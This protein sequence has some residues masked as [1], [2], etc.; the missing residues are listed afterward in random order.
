MLYLSDTTLAS[1]E[2]GPREIVARI[3]HLLQGVVAGTVS[4][5]PK[6]TLYPGDG[7]LFMS[8][9]A[10]SE[11]PPYMTVKSLGMNP[12]NGERD[13]PSIG[14]HIAL[15]DAGTGL[16]VAMMDGTWITAVRTAALTAV[17]A[18]RLADADAATIAF[19]GCGVQARSHLDV[20]AELYPITHI[21]M[22]GRGKANID[23]LADRAGQLNIEA[24]RA[25]DSSAA[26]A[27]ADIVVSTVPPSV[28]LEAFLDANVLKENAFVSMVD[29][30]RSWKPQTL[31]AF[32]AI[33]VDDL[34][35]ERQMAS[36]M[37]DLSLV[38]RDLKSLVQQSPGSDGR[39]AFVF[40]GVAVGDLALAG[41][42]YERALAGG[43][44]Q[45]LET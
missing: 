41:L 29:L 34:D 39:R 11:D 44:G 18:S 17:A 22:I 20:L 10:S 5:A 43:L 6:S 42:C 26:L 3:E 30:G 19:V 31:T 25:Q 32:D 27:Q 33:V 7:R 9:L 40:R 2:I 23:A 8:T 45:T 21:S 35:Q 28:G 37:V 24:M 14:A 1:L 12:A 38:E 13:L 4:S 36:P 16:P 15:F